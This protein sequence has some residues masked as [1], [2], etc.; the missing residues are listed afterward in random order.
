MDNS[1]LTQKALSLLPD[2]KDRADFFLRGISVFYPEVYFGERVGKAKAIASEYPSRY[3]SFGRDQFASLLFYAT[4]SYSTEEAL[5]IVNVWK[6]YFETHG[7]DKLQE[8]A[9]TTPDAIWLNEQLD[10]LEEAPEE[11]TPILAYQ[12][13]RELERKIQ[14]RKEREG[15]KIK[16]TPK[17]EIPQVELNNEDK[18]Q[19][20]NLINAVRKDPATFEKTIEDK[21][22]EAVDKSAPEVRSAIDETII[23]KTASTFTYNIKEAGKSIKNI[24]DIPDQ[25]SSVHPSSF[26]SALTNPDNPKFQK[27]VPDTATRQEIAA[28]I[29]TLSL[30]LNSERQVNTSLLNSLFPDKIVQVVEG[31]SRITQFEIADNQEDADAPTI[32]INQT[33]RLGKDVSDLFAKVSTGE[34]TLGEVSATSLAAIPTFGK[35]AVWLAQKSSLSLLSSVLL[36]TTGAI[37]GTTIGSAAGALSSVGVTPLL[38]GPGGLVWAT[39]ILWTHP[40]FNLSLGKYSFNIISGL[41]S[42]GRLFTFGVINTGRNFFGIMFGKQAQGIGV[43]TF[44]SKTG[45]QQVAPK[46][47]GKLATLSPRLAS[48]FAKIGI[49]VSALGTFLGGLLGLAIGWFVGKVVEKTINWVKK[50]WEDIKLALTVATVSLLAKKVVTKA[51]KLMARIASTITVTI[52]TPV[53]VAIFVFPFIVVLVLFIINSGAY[54]VPPDKFSLVA[55][56][57]FVEVR[58]KAAPGG[59]FA[60]GDLPL[61]ITYTIT[62]TAKKGALTNISFG[63]ACQVI[64]K[65]NGF[66]CP[67][68][69]PTEIPTEISPASPFVFTYEATY[70]GDS[71][72]DA[73]VLNTFSITADTDEAKGTSSSSSVAII[74]GNPPASCYKLTGSWPSEFEANLKAAIAYLI[75]NHPNYLTKLC[76]VNGNIRE[77]IIS[78]DPS[79]TTYWG[80]ATSA[81]TITLYPGGLHNSTDATYIL[82]HES[83]HLLSWRSPS[84]L[85]MYDSSSAVQAERPYCSYSATG[86]SYYGSFEGFAEAAALY[87]SPKTFYCMHFSFKDSYPNS[88]KFENDVIFK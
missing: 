34:I 32:D 36:P 68:P 88:W 40:V 61:K 56:N 63:H 2:S 72:Q 53:I 4:D 7:I 54:L 14:E 9:A 50:H 31:P 51:V 66:E 48:I 33:Y 43:W 58:K 23:K 55:E 19:L 42:K 28:K 30:L 35:P 46:L 82:A 13:A 83:A 74:I 12:R 17:E 70:S 24:K 78:Y 69:L 57:P 15:R 6:K 29:R 1:Q 16:V 65:T 81:N 22:R 62:I 41:A 77:I 25:I 18:R 84:F 76:S 3:G 45:Y 60:N 86:N 87:G 67:H 38:P 73:L 79:A 71:Y 21:L 85:D 75:S 37:V 10:K 26:F 5:A 52:A 59:P 27:M 49:A 8:P 39:N 44:S 80:W 11:K 47:I 64:K 20:I